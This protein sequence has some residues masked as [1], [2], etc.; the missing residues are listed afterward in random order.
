MTQV[1]LDP[2]DLQPRPPDRELF[3]RLLRDFVPD[4]PF[5]FHAHLYR[6]GDLPESF[7]GASA[8]CKVG[9]SCYRR[10]M[11]AWMGDRAPSDGMFFGLPERGVDIASANEFCLAETAE[12]SQSRALLMIGPEDDP[13]AV[14]SLVAA[15]SPLVAGFKVYH[16]F[17][18][19]TD[20]IIV[21][22]RLSGQ[23]FDRPVLE[24]GGWLRLV[25]Q[26]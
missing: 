11:T 4:H 23:Q 17:A 24:L 12:A 14:E 22:Q 8:P 7:A 20:T 13:A 10:Q 3:D 16:V 5:D 1:S 26:P 21:R 19:R 9:L 2:S 6:G 15:N 25:L 18:D